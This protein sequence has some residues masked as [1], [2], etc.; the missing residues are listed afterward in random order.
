MSFVD[1]ARLRSAND[2]TIPFF[3]IRLPF[4]TSQVRI[5]TQYQ[6]SMV[7]KAIRIVNSDAVNSLTWRTISNSTPLETLEPATEATARE[8]TSYIEINP[9]AA[10]GKGLLEIELVKQEDAYQK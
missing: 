7:A 3:T 2:T 8:W 10:T 1:F 4:T 6:Y 9:N 5:D